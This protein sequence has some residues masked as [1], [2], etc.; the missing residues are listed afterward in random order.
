MG[1]FINR[2]P[3]EEAGGLNLY[4]FTGNDGVNRRDWLGLSGGMGEDGDGGSWWFPSPSYGPSFDFGF[5]DHDSETFV[6]TPPSVFKG[7]RSVLLKEAAANGRKI[8]N[9]GPHKMYADWER[10]PNREGG[11]APHEWRLIDPINSNAAWSEYLGRPGGGTPF[12]ISVWLYQGRLLISPEANVSGTR[13]TMISAAL[14]AGAGAVEAAAF[15][16]FRFAPQSSTQMVLHGDQVIMNN[17]A[18]YYNEGWSQTVGRFN[19]GEITIP[20]G[21]NWRTVLGQYTDAAARGRLRNFLA[22]EGIAEG[23]GADVLV[24]RWLRDPSGSGAYRIPDVRLMQTGTILDGTIGTKTMAT[25][26]VQDFIKFSGGN[27]VI[28]V[29]PTVQP[30]P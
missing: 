10:A 30:V 8:A 1:R 19:A 2:D 4:G 11:Q 24:N 14:M 13:D 22:R 21:Q 20:A 6:W 7:P 28:I 27:R 15:F 25:P 3:I 5:D 26:Q 29:R 17:Y 9:S 12:E 16:P 23:P 18:R